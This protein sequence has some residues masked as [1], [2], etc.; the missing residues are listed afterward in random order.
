MQRLYTK[1]HE[2]LDYEDDIVTVGITDHAQ[3]MLG[4]I[5][6]LDLVPTGTILAAGDV[7]ATVESVKAASDIYAPIPGEVV[8]VNTSI[9]DNPAA[10]NTSA[11]TT[12]WLFRLRLSSPETTEGMMDETA[13]RNYAG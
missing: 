1:E 13:Y 4:D 8:E 9:V 5:V 12:A 3:S 7:A 6:F 2:W 11:E 10:L